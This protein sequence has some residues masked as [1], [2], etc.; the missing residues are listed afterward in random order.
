MSG[1]DIYGQ[2]TWTSHLLH[3]VKLKKGLKTRLFFWDVTNYKTQA[4]AIRTY[5]TW[6]MITPG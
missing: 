2:V 3:A 5:N 4:E 1:L 6:L